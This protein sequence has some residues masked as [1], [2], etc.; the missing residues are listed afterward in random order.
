MVHGTYRTEKAEGFVADFCPVCRDIASFKMIRVGDASHLAFVSV[1]NGRFAGRLIRCSRCDTGRAFDQRRYT[2][3][4]EKSSDLEELIALTHPN[5]RTEFGAR[6]DL[7]ARLRADSSI[8]S[9]PQREELLLEPF[10]ELEPEIAQLDKGTRHQ[11]KASM[12]G[13]LAMCLTIG[14]VGIV[15]RFDETKTGWAIGGGIIAFVLV[16][17]GILIHAE[18]RGMKQRI[19]PCLARAL[20]PLHPTKEELQNILARCRNAG[21]RSGKKVKLDSL[22]RALQLTSA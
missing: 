13:F 1:G 19:M 7:E 9:A 21:L 10:Q 20:K 8:L 5:V 3:V 22:W 14:A 6:L 2:G 17:A 16:W 11:K 15:N 12:W 18:G 4:A